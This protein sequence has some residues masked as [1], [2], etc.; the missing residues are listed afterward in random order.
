M[1]LLYPCHLAR[2]GACRSPRRATRRSEKLWGPTAKKENVKAYL[3][4]EVPRRPSVSIQSSYAARETRPTGS[5]ASRRL[6][7]WLDG[8]GEYQQKRN[9]G[10]EAPCEKLRVDLKTVHRSCSLPSI[11]YQAV[12]HRK[13]NRARHT[14]KDKASHRCPALFDQ[15]LSPVPSRRTELYQP[16]HV[17]NRRSL[18]RF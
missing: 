12:L 16:C 10:V 1:C 14:V 11:G 17:D 2:N 4:T 18:S 6:L 5:C 8:S 9:Y 3:R 7:L 15:R 13:V